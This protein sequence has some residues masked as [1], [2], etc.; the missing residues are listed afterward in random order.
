M[1]IFQGNGFIAQHVKLSNMYEAA[2][3]TVDRSVSLPYWDFTMEAAQGTYIYESPIMSPKMF[4]SMTAPEGLNIRYGYRYENDKIDDYAIKDGRWAYITAHKNPDKFAALEAGYG[5]MR[6]PWNMNPSK[7]IT[8]F[9]GVTNPP[10]C[11]SHYSMVS[12]YTDLMDFMISVENSA[13]ATTHGGIGG[14]YGCDMFDPLLEK[15]YISSSSSLLAICKLWI[16]SLK[17]LY[18]KNFLI[19]STGCELPDDVQDASCPF[20]CNVPD[21]ASL[22][23]TLKNNILGGYIPTDI[24]AEGMTAWINF[25]CGGDASRVFSGDHLESASPTDPSFWPM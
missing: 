23:L 18:R 2:I 16:F 17:V 12:D 8:R 25:V 7:Y 1:V 13:H 15:G 5:Y 4:G 21:I 3:Q 6:S 24:S 22:T 20:Q 19:A 11:K 10:D 14:S 9:S